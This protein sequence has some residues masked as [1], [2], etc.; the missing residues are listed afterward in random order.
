MTSWG[1]TS[2]PAQ[3]I[4]SFLGEGTPLSALSRYT[5]SCLGPTLTDGQARAG[6]KS[7]VTVPVLH[8]DITA[9][10]AW[11]LTAVA[12]GWGPGGR[13]MDPALPWGATRPGWLWMTGEAPAGL[14]VSV[15]ICPAP[16]STEKL[17]GGDSNIK[18]GPPAL[19]C[20]SGE[21]RLWCHGHSQL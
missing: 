15:S 16:G 20:G 12:G 6:L 7:T 17:L 1:P 18:S 2:S 8:R 9:L 21:A 14:C 3:A 4:N 19:C 11:P 10:A 13:K 5:T